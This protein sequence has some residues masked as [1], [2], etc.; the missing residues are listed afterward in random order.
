M[1]YTE[2][3]FVVPSGFN[4]TKTV[5]PDG[6]CVYTAKPISDIA[7]NQRKRM[8][9]P[10]SVAPWG[11]NEYWMHPNPPTQK[12]RDFMNLLKTAIKLELPKFWIPR[13]APSRKENGGICY[14]PGK[15]PALDMSF[16]EWCIAAKEFS[17]AFGSCL[18]TDLEYVVVLATL[19][20]AFVDSGMSVE[21]AWHSVCVNSLALGHYYN[22]PDTKHTVEPTG[23]RE[24]FGVCDY[25]NVNYIVR[26]SDVNYDFCLAGG[27]YFDESSRRPLATLLKIRGTYNN[28]KYDHATGLIK[29]TKDPGF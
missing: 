20:K 29:L 14:E 13:C 4:V 10:Y 28:N 22:S 25:G 2:M 1:S 19:I 11:L 8:F 26:C 9:I 16:N 27:S 5:L 12:E 6:R 23:R 17:P 3:R 7:Y 15:M 24:I 21:S 18:C